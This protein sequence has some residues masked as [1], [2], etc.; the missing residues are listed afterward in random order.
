MKKLKFKPKTSH[1]IR[2]EKGIINKK[3][4]SKTHREYGY[5]QGKYNKFFEQADMPKEVNNF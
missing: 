2:K 3:R 1:T 5:K 4:G